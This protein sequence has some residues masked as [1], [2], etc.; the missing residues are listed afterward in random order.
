MRINVVFGGRSGARVRFC[1]T[2]FP[3]AANFPSGVGAELTRRR[4]GF[5][6]A[7]RNIGT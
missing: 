5:S 3:R 1:A 2:R 7:D 6:E 4:A